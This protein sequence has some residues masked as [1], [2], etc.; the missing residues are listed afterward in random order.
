MKEIMEKILTEKAARN[1][2]AIATIAAAQ[3]EFDTWN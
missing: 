3:E 2:R 1:S